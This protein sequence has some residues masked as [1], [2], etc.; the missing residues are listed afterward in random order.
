MLALCDDAADQGMRCPPIYS[1][2]ALVV[3]AAQKGAEAAEAASTVYAGWWREIRRVNGGELLVVTKAKGRIQ[4][5]EGLDDSAKRR[6][7]GNNTADKLARKRGCPPCCGQLPKEAHE[8]AWRAY[9]ARATTV[10]EVL[11]LWPPPKQLNGEQLKRV[12]GAQHEKHTPP[13]ERHG[14]WWIGG[15]PWACL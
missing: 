3:D 13:A 5:T 15:K 9:R 7:V 12:A 14:L 1:D 10:V 2:C 4:V 11:S 6:A 8:A